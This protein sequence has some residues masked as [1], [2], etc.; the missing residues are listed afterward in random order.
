MGMTQ[1][2][3]DFGS[4]IFAGKLQRTYGIKT[5]YIAG[6]THTENVAQ[7]WSKI[8]SADVLLS[9]QLRI[10]AKEIDRHGYHLPARAIM[11]DLQVV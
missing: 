7:T 8:N 2:H 10:E 9:L 6:Q 5:G 4:Q 11:I 1:N 3:N